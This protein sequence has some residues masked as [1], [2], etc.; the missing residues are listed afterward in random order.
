MTLVG[1]RAGGLTGNSKGDIE[2]KALRF[3]VLLLRLGVLNRKRIGL[4]RGSSLV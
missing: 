2:A 3:V 4:T 1:S